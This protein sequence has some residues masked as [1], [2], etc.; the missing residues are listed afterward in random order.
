MVAPACLRSLVA[1]AS[2]A[3]R[4]PPTDLGADPSAVG[5]PVVAVPAEEEDLPAQPAD[6]EAQ[7]IQGSG[8]DRQELD[9]DQAPCDEGLVGAGSGRTA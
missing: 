9:A 8:R 7:R 6:D 3:L 5:V 4:G 2:L 1:L